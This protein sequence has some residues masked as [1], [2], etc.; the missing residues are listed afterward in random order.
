M[1][2]IHIQHW[3]ENNLARR[4]QDTEGGG[5]KHIMK[6]KYSNK[7]TQNSPWQDAN[8]TLLTSNGGRWSLNIKLCFYF[9]WQYVEALRFYSLP[10]QWHQLAGVRGGAGTAAPQPLY[11]FND[12]KKKGFFPRTFYPRWKDSDLIRFMANLTP[13]GHSSHLLMV[14]D[15]TLLPKWCPSHLEHS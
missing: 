6:G 10:K 14:A 5:N 12:R 8:L 3:V 2:P 15:K 1:Y 7:N 11:S 13:W 4:E 9:C